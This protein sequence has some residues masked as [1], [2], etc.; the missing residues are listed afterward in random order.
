MIS[1]YPGPSRLYSRIPEF[2][3]EACDK[4]VLSI[5]HRSLEFVEISKKTIS[6][7]KQKLNVPE[8]YTVFFTSSATEC[9]E[10]IAQSLI[11]KKSFHLYNG[12]FGEKWL[13]YTQK[14]KKESSGIKFEWEEALN[15][16]KFLV[17]EDAELLAITQ[18]ETSNATEV[19]N[20]ILSSYRLNYPDKLIAV[21]A[22]SS[23]A[24]VYLDFTQAD[25]W[26]ASVQKCF[27]LP[28]GM[29][30]MVCSPKTIERAI[31]LNENSH[32]NSLISMIERMKDYQTTYT[33]NV[34]SVFLLMK[35]LEMVVPIHEMD[36]TIRGNA[37][38]W[39][40]FLKEIKG[41]ELLVKN[42][43]VRSGTVIAV[44]GKE[45][46]ISKIKKEA[47]EADLLLGNGYGS[48]K[49]S[50]FRIAN[51]PAL[52]TVEFNKLKDFLTSFSLKF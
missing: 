19:S 51:F 25:I 44:K 34:L 16:E 37:E 36:K 46:I 14:L 20:T 13:E 43:L 29:A 47:K 31:G 39:Y 45:E 42:P 1:F 49:S 7:F 4:G 23:M 10:I 2:M 48:W 27:G 15:V 32:Y 30:V 22:T 12:A 18:N 52:E 50:T 33:P 5:N 24:G 17:P 41:I 40:G 21:D 11:K 6:L 8:E 26:Y 35:V 9:W 28:A 38:N 3:Q